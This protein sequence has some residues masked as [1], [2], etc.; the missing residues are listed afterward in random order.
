MRIA[1]IHSERLAY[2]ITVLCRVM[3]VARSGYHAWAVRGECDR[4]RRDR[5]LSV[6]I[7]AVFERSMSRLRNPGKTR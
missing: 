5:V 7:A 6:H 4:I 1:F 3:Q 2:P